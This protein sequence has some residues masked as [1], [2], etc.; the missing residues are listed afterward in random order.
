M[1]EGPLDPCVLRSRWLHFAVGPA[2]LDEGEHEAGK[3]D[4]DADG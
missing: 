4:A 1:Q 3:V 2:D